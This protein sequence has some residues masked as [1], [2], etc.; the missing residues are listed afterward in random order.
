M[1]GQQQASMA[2][3]KRFGSRCR[4]YI[5][6]NLNRNAHLRCTADRQ[7]SGGLLGG[8]S[9]F[10]LALWEGM[11]DSRDRSLRVRLFT[12]EFENCVRECLPRYES[13]ARPAETP[14]AQ[15]HHF[16]VS[17]AENDTIRDKGNGSE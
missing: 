9:Q 17:D 13:P 4:C 16:S 8:N 11:E 5:F 6:A 10:W 2:D 15:R 7:T 3:E 14:E 1:G 12:I